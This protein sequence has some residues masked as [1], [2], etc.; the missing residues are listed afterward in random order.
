[1]DGEGVVPV[2]HCGFEDPAG[3]LRRLGQVAEAVVAVGRDEMGQVCLEDVAELCE[4]G[5]AGRGLRQR[6]FV[7][8]GLELAHGEVVEALGGPPLVVQLSAQVDRRLIVPRGPASP[9]EHGHVIGVDHVVEGECRGR[10]QPL[11]RR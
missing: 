4:V 2:P 11:R 7:P 9:S 1:M 5:L 3:P 10:R 6:A 8:P